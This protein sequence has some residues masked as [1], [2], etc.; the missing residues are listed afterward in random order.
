MFKNIRIYLSFHKKYD[1]ELARLNIK[2]FTFILFLLI[3]INTAEIFLFSNYFS[4]FGWLS[5]IPFGVLLPALVFCICTKDSLE[6]AYG[7]F[8]KITAFTALFAL[9]WAAAVA[10]R[11]LHS[12]SHVVTL[13]SAIF[14]VSF[15]V[16]MKPLITICNYTIMYIF[17]I[18]YCM[19]LNCQHEIIN[20]H[21]IKIFL[22]TGIAIAI[23]IFLYT[24]KIKEC[25]NKEEIEQKNINLATLNEKLK[26]LNE[27][28]EQLA[29]TDYL[30]GL[31]NRRQFDVLLHTEWH[32]ALRE[33]TPLSMIMLDVDFFKEFND[34][35]GHLA[36]DDC[37]KS[38]GATLLFT[39][40]RPRDLAFRYG[41][42]EFACILPLTDSQGA[43]HICDNIRQ[44][45]HDLAIR[46]EGS[47]I[48]DRVTF[49][50]GVVSGIPKPGGTPETFKQAADKLLYQAK[51]QG[52]NKV[53]YATL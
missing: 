32:S 26:N 41:G 25:I 2:K 35:Y 33:A 40:S 23:S 44:A 45:I 18:S 52:R 29:G 43:L 49:S 28:L 37:L 27:K 16:Y 4:V 19:Y 20:I 3:I 6:H 10:V 9:L 51:A 39:L 8:N 5:W 14:L 47:S 30:T 53:V 24:T 38:L 42:E 15:I 21:S 7:A 1:V 17:F 13:V 34:R 22:F 11:H 46:H 36:G 12:D 48:C 31:Y 50:Y